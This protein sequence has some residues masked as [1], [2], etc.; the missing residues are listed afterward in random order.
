MLIKLFE[1]VNQATIT[2]DSYDDFTRKVPIYSRMLNRRNTA[3]TSDENDEEQDILRGGRP[4]K[5]GTPATIPLLPKVSKKRRR[6]E[7]PNRCLN[8]R[9]FIPLCFVTVYALTVM[10]CVVL[11]V[12]YFWKP[13]QLH[14]EPSWRGD[15]I[16]HPIELQY[17]K[18][19]RDPHNYPQISQ[20]ALAMCT[21]ALWHTIE[22]TTIV[23]PN[24]ETFIHT[25]DI[26]DLWL[27]DSAAQIH[28][29]MIPAFGPNRT[30][31]LIQTDAKLDRIVSGLIKRSAM[32]I[33]HDPYANAVSF[34]GLFKSYYIQMT[35]LFPTHISRF[36]LDLRPSSE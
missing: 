8:F 6:R 13:K 17:P 3:R 34:W 12:R 15:V 28:T 23:L 1:R 16:V 25:G 2:T 11:L 21:K 29:L 7:T 30:S 31:A 14:V 26:D 5:N 20:E 19:I 36:P 18:I 32:Y 22:T 9:R 24:M 27:R 35:V 10:I 4:M 33:R